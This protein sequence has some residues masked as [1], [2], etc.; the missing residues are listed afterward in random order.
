MYTFLVR[1]VCVENHKISRSFTYLVSLVCVC[2]SSFQGE[3]ERERE[4][5][6]G[7]IICLNRSC[8]PFTQASPYQR[9]IQRPWNSLYPSLSLFLSF[10]R[11]G[12][13]HS[14]VVHFAGSV[15]LSLSFAFRRLQ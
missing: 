1:S 9:E 6:F 7:P 14:F 5:E 11:L 8:V 13:L 2:V 10:C 3:R 12:V 15:T 4:S